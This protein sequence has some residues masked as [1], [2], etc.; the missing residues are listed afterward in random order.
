MD[1]KEIL[2]RYWEGQTTLEEER[3][4]KKHFAKSDTG[5]CENV[6]FGAFTSAS[7]VQSEMDTEAFLAKAARARP[8]R[9]A[10][11]IMAA[12]AALV[13]IMATAI[14]T[15]YRPKVYAYVNGTPV[16]DYET[17]YEYTYEALALLNDNLNQSMQYID[18]VK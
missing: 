9:R 17:A 12:A 7:A 18:M 15:E 13:A 1:Y 11:A 14:Y 10:W 16:T 4:L 3:A 8:R 5:T 2:E 6:I